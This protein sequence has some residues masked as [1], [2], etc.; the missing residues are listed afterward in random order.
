MVGILSNAGIK[1]PKLLF[2][3]PRPDY[4][5]VF[6]FI[7]Q[8]YNIKEIPVLKHK[9]IKLILKEV[10]EIGE[11]DKKSFKDISSR[12]MTDQYLKAQDNILK[13]ATGRE[14]YPEH[15]VTIGGLPGSKFYNSPEWR[16]LRYLA[17]ERLGN[18][19]Q[20]CGVTARKGKPVHVDHIK[21]R[22]YYPELALNI[23]NLQI[24]CEDCN[25]GKSNR[26]QKDWRLS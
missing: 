6:Q 21:P 15:Q 17:L 26:F 5:K 24:L 1:I 16:G 10:I 25:I 20:A 13:K 9:T 7:C 18:T 12:H 3:G 11:I 22:S 8:K 2:R 19:C 23:N 4:G 14:I